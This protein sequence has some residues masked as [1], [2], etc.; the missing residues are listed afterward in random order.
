MYKIDEEEF[1]FEMRF[2]AGVNTLNKYL[3]TYTVAIYE[4]FG[5]EG[6]KLITKIWSDMA[7]RFFLKSFE[8]LGFEGNGPKEIAEWFA[9]ADGLIGYNT[10]FFVISD[11]KA[12][13]RINKCPW[14]DKPYPEGE[15]LCGE[16]VTGFEKRSAQL[17]NPK[18][19]FSMGKCF[20]KG[21]GFCEFIFEL[22]GE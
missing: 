6:L 5:D 8:K 14:F 19:K 17:L 4:R 20:H 22:P 11:K 21:D 10:D 2:K 9:K 13:F 1:P 7:D 15:K 18:L 12:G 3:A 16:G